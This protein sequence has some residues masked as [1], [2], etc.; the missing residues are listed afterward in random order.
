MFHSENILIIIET[1][2]DDLEDEYLE[3]H[4]VEIVKK[5]IA[6]AEMKNFDESFQF[7][8]LA[9][10]E[11]PRSPSI[12]N[13]RAQAL[14]LVNRDE[15]ISIYLLCDKSHKEILTKLLYK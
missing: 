12:L 4:I 5:A 3:S 14:R 9:L 2:D 10:T 1:V 8:N 7:F 13:D 11:K 15:G 6:C